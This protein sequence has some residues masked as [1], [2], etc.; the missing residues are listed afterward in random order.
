MIRESIDRHRVPK[1]RSVLTDSPWLVVLLSYGGLFCMSCRLA[2]TSDASVGRSA[3]T[4]AGAV[5]GET[6]AILA[7]QFYEVADLYFHRGVPHRRESALAIDLFR[8]LRE[9]VSPSVHTHAAGQSIREIMPWLWMTIRLDPDRVDP[10]LVAAF[11]L[12]GEA[13]RPDLALDVLLEAQRNIAF[14]YEIQMAKG[15]IYLRGGDIERARSAFD[16]ALAFLPRAA[17]PG[18]QEWRMDKAEALLY[19]ALIHEADGRYAEA[20]GLLRQV[21]V[22]FP[23]RTT[24]L[25]RIEALERGTEPEGLAATIWNAMLR[26]YARKRSACH[27][28]ECVTAAGGHDHGHGHGHGHDHDDDHGEHGSRIENHVH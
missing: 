14:S 19:R 8:K 7:S 5:F 9:E 3:G 16:A 28:D 10:Y 22:L 15:R 17:D 13:A 11:W 12:A 24:L 26:D 2:I 27:R 1:P 23:D 21:L 20:A 18:G 25:V 4:V 6:R